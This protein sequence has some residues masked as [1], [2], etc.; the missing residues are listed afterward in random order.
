MTKAQ[1]WNC[2]SGVRLKN[3]F[4]FQARGEF[5]RLAAFNEGTHAF[6]DSVD[7]EEGEKKAKD[8]RRPLLLNYISRYFTAVCLRSV[9][10]IFYIC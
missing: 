5:H 7:K 2:D 1:V 4:H 9:S 6:R 10:F 3:A 8:S